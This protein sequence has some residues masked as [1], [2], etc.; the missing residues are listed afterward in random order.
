VA[1]Q[2]FFW[3]VA[4]SALLLVACGEEPQAE[5]ASESPSGG[6]VALSEP[7]AAFPEA[8]SFIQNVRE[9]SD[10]RVM[11][12]DPLGQALVLADLDAAAAD[13]LGRVGQGP[14]EYQQPDAVWPLPADTTLVVDLGNGRLTQVAPDGT[15]GETWPLFQ[16][17]PGPTMV[18]TL[19][20]ALDARGRI[21]IEGRGGMTRGELPDS[22]PVLRVERGGETVDTVAIVKLQERTMTRSGGPGNQ[23]VS[24]DLVPL[25]AADAW[26]VAPDGRIAV[27]RSDDYHLEWIASDGSVVTGTPVAFDPV[28][29]GQAEKEEW[30][31]QRSLSGGGLSISLSMDNGAAQMS[32]RRGGSGGSR[33]ETDFDRYEWPDAKPPFYNGIVRVDTEGRAWVRR[34]VEAGEPPLYDVF[35][36]QARHVGSV[37]LPMSR[38]LVGFGPSGLYAVYVDDFDLNYVERYELP[39]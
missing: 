35:D 39:M 34:H 9:L 28:P 2:A 32:M 5:G 8:Y 22:A 25:S 38:R 27:V 10:G 18:L 14:S 31:R 7:T 26:G 37:Q 29:I 16:G 20:E 3:M 6:V 17:E 23:N 30:D 11:W 1:I 33:D 4:P 36:T 19:P 12:A 21:Y 24:I 15:F 13:T